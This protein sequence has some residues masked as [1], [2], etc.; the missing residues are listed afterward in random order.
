MIVICEMTLRCGDK[1][2]RVAL[3]SPQLTRAEAERLWDEAGLL[4]RLRAVCDR[5]QAAA[6][7]CSIDV[8]EVGGRLDHA[9]L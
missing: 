7:P 8:V 5:A 1:D 3:L 4:E 2:S 9:P 6:A